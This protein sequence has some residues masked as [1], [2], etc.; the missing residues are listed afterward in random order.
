MI[1]TDVKKC[2]LCKDEEVAPECIKVCPTNAV[3]VVAD[4]AFSC[5][6]CGTCARECPTKA[7]KK[8]EYGGYYVDRKKCTGCGICANV[9]PISIIEIIDD[10][11]IGKKHPMGICVMCGLCAE[12]CP[13]HARMCLNVSEMKSMK[14]KVLLDRYL[15]IFKTH[16]NIKE[17]IQEEKPA[18]IIKEKDK[19]KIRTSIDIDIGGKCVECGRCIYLCPKN[20]ILEKEE[21]DGCTGCNICELVC[22]NEA[23]E[24]G[25]VDE[26]KCVLCGNCIEKCPKEALEIKNFK[27]VKTKEDEKAT[28][29]KHCINCGLCVDRC[30]SEALRI[31]NSKILYDPSICSLC[32]TCVK[33]CPQGVRVNK[34]DRS[35]AKSVKSQSDFNF[36]PSVRCNEMRSI[37]SNYVD[38]GCVLCN[39]CVKN[40]PEDAIQIKEVEKFEI[41]KDVNCI[42]CGTCSNV[43]PNDAI[44]VK[45][46]KFSPKVSSEVIFDDNCVMC[47]NCAIHCPRDVI[48]NTT[49]HKK[50]VD[51]ENS[52]IRTDMDYCIECGLCNKIC[53]NEAID[54]G[55]IDWDNCELCSACVNICPTHAVNIYR[56]W[57]ERP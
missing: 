46:T 41:I 2:K 6:T 54:K 57:V 7:I 26:E 30:P 28:P 43:C 52:Y 50:V 37:S 27:I 8:N 4:K 44:T 39:I 22:P 32:N 14:N 48:P 21:V 23:I 40:C 49:G 47:E 16:G 9:C 20:T 42:G 18:K 10:E 38:G 53:P 1:V 3:K 35:E 34:G 25:V 36:E 33:I 55:K 31:E 45:I 13:N 19:R 24:Y 15:M 29:L 56:T 17:H 5:I 11:K 12:A 51:R